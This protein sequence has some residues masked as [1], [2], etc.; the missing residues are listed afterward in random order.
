M[1]NDDVTCPHDGGLFDHSRPAR[2]V[3]LMLTAPETG[4]AQLLARPEYTDAAGLVAAWY[5][6]TFTFRLKGA[7]QRAPADIGGHLR[8]SFLGALG[9]GASPE[10]QAGRP[11]PWD[12]PCALDVFRREQLRGPKGDGLPKPHIIRAWPRGT[13]LIAT[14]RIF[15][16]AGDWAMTA[17]EAMALGIRE[18]LPWPR[19]VAGLQTPPEIV[20]RT[21]D[22]SRLSLEPAPRQ[23][24]LIFLSPIDGTGADIAAKPHSLITRLIRRVDAMSRWN[25]VAMDESAGRALAHHA[26]R[27]DYDLTGLRPGRYESP[28]RHRQKRHDPTFGGRIVISSDLAPIWPILLLGARCHVGRHAVEGLG[29]FRLDTV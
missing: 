24:A 3:Q 12:P 27:L 25:G 29:A 20:E 13:D 23:V 10:A 2:H 11:C 17:A 5:D 15:G 19:V 8:R 28:N 22:I 9:K 14:L 1:V 16:M 21:V 6:Q 7:G 18:I 4:L 26:A